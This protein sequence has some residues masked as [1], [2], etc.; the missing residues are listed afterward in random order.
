[1]GWFILSQLFSTMITLV[2]LGRLCEA[3]KD[4][5]ILFLRQQISILLR[6]RVQPVNATRV[7]K[8]KLTAFAARLKEITNRSATQLGE[9]MRLFQPETVLGWHRELVRRKWTF[10]HKA[11]GGRPRLSQEIEDLITRMVKENS[12]WG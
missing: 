4:L 9:I 1:M 7:E 5:E 11:R 12:L 10:T 8:L 3:E 2:I 6:N